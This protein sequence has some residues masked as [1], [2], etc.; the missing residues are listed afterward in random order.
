LT[1]IAAT[2]GPPAAAVHTRLDAVPEAVGSPFWEAD[3]LTSAL[4]QA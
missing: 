4:N 2:I 1:P 3:D